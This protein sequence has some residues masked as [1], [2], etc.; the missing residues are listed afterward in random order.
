MADLDA[1]G[2][3][4]FRRMAAIVGFE[5]GPPEVMTALALSGSAAQARVQRF[6]AD[7]DFFERI[8]ILRRRR[9]RPRAACSRA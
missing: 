5:Y 7:A 3:D 6:P 2:L 4:H 9:G 1:T 8:H